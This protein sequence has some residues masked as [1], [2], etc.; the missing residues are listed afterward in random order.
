MKRLLF[1]L[2]GV[3]LA[4]NASA[5]WTVRSVP[6]TRLQGNEI[7]VSDPDGYLSD[8]A[9]S[10][11]N[12]ALSDIRDQADVFLVT[13]YSI[14]DDEPKHFATALF[15]YWG[16]GD[17]ETDNG[18][19]LLFVEDQH[20]L[21]FET[22]YGAESTMTDATCAQ[23]FNRTIVPYF[24]LGDYEGGLCAGVADIV[25]VYGGIVPM[26]LKSMTSSYPESAA[27][28]DLDI[29]WGEVGG[30][31]SLLVIMLMVFLV[32]IISF[33]RW[34]A[35]LLSGKKKKN[36]QE[37]TADV[38]EQEG[39]K[40]IKDVSTGWKASVWEGKGFLRLL[41][42]GVGAVVIFLFA[43]S[44]VSKIMP[45]ASEEKQYFWAFLS[46][47]I[48]YF[49]ATGLI[50]NTML[51]SK[52]NKAA[53]TS[54]SPRNIYRLAKND[55]HSLMTRVLAPWIGIP[56]SIMLKKRMKQSVQCVC[57]AC[58]SDMMADETFQLPEK[59]AAE[60]MAGGYHFT[61]CRCANGHVYVLREHG[62]HYGSV[63]FCKACGVFASK[64]IKETTTVSPTY[65]SSGIKTITYECQYCH[66]KHV[67]TQSIPKL[68]RSTSSGS[69]Y[70][71]SSHHSSGHS[72]GSFGGGRSG[73]GGYSGRW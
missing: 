51:L 8:S 7:H 19:L 41:V 33:F 71:S 15:N 45:E 50:Q 47:W 1:L 34:I 57:P 67:V 56:F 42:Y 65:S 64:K 17:A 32:P 46:G 11:I 12:T 53:K 10:Y 44:Y 70:H 48:V 21:E 5:Q 43:M 3:L 54:K 38:F 39:L 63:V 22:G 60:E 23:I 20:A 30:L 52:A 55:P 66:V 2:I 27:D 6:N 29:T 26:G 13:L 68:T 28:E 4:L 14:G 59:R 72:S 61:P 9:E 35:G 58:G 73:G 24:K 69:G 25:E 62:S 16:V 49:T 36:D 40:L 18:V 31:F 37:E